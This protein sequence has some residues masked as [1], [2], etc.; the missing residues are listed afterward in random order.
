M[1]ILALS[2]LSLTPGTKPSEFP[3]VLF[4]PGLGYRD[5]VLEE[6]TPHFILAHST[7]KKK[8][9]EEPPFHTAKFYSPGA[10]VP[11]FISRDVEGFYLL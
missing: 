5:Q 1:F 9:T 2:S 7:L 3:L 4:S 10:N 6:N 8:P 11:L